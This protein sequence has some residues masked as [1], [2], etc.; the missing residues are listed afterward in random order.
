MEWGRWVAGFSK[1]TPA[2]S[3]LYLLVVAMGMSMREVHHHLHGYA[4][5]TLSIRDQ[6]FDWKIALEHLQRMLLLPSNRDRG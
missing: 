4:L 1:R 5:S 2:L 3:K 6:S